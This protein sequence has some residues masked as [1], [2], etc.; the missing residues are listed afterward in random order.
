M[1]SIE[2]PFRV[3]E[4]LPM[5]QRILR[6]NEAVIA[7][8]ARSTMG[9]KTIYNLVTRGKRDPSAYV[10]TYN[11]LRGNMGVV[12]AANMAGVSPG[13]MSETLTAWEA[14]GIIYDIGDGTRPVY[15]RMLRLPL[16]Q[17][18]D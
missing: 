13:T 15:M 3:T 5:D 9:V 16:K 8:L 4:R 1:S 14:Q 18:S 11:S 12:D 7:L 17:P 6:Q 2:R 10:R